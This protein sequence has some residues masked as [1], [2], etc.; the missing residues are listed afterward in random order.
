[1]RDLTELE[2]YRQRDAERKLYGI[3]GDSTCGVFKVFVSGRSFNVI[4]SA[5]GGWDHVSVT[6]PCGKIPTWDE[7]CAIKE[8]FFLDNEV[9]VQYHPKKSE[10]VNIHTGCLH[11]WRPHNVEMPTPPVIYV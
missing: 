4:A 5:G 11:L 9:V 1:M 8:M 7:M 2:K 6:R 10:Y 3:N